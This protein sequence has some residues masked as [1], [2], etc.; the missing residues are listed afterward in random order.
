MMPDIPERADPVT[1][2]LPWRP[3]LAVTAVAALATG[4]ALL[5]LLPA[6]TG[7]ESL[8]VTTPTNGSASD[9]RTVVVSGTGADDAIIRIYDAHSNA[10]LLGSTKVIDGTFSTVVE[11]ADDAPERQGLYVDAIKGDGFLDADVVDITLPAVEAD[12]T[13]TGSSSATANSPR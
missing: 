9:T 8:I 11:Y 4:G 3:V 2:S 13:T 5:T 7:E 1:M 6:S 10:I 12:G